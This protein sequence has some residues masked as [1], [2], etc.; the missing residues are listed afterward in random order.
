MEFEQI[1]KQLEW[2][3]KQQ[4]ENTDAIS[5]M[6]SR[7]ISLESTVGVVSKQIK[8]LSKQLSDITP[9]SETG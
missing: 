6:D 7:M 5:T 1:V 8:S 9:C 2:L 3:D 4:R